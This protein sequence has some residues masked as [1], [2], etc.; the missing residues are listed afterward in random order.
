MRNA[1]RTAELQAEE[2]ALQAE[3]QHLSAELLKV[4]ADP[5]GPHGTTA[6]ELIE[7]IEG[8]EEDLATLA[9]AA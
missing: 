1:G 8:V 3:L 5:F 6:D 4:E 7:T 2:A 9:A